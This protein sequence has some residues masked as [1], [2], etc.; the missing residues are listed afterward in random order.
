VSD[1]TE[2]ESVMKMHLVL[3]AA[4][5]GLSSHAAFAGDTW[6]ELQPNPHVR[7]VQPLT[8]PAPAPVS[9]QQRD[10]LGATPARYDG[11]DTWS[12]LA[13]K[14]SHASLTE[15]LT[16]ATT[17]PLS[18]LHHE[19]PSVYGTSVQADT[20]DRIVRLAPDS[21]S[22][23]VAYGESVEFIVRGE[24]GAER[25]FAWRFDGSP[26]RSYVDLSEVAPAGFPD[27]SLR[28]FVAPDARYRGE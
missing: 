1:F 10:D 12:D 14:S 21:H 5:T 6:S 13:P 15:S 16:V 4:L 18:T 20:A 24:S 3:A 11:G 9:S 17:A 23:N 19:S 2:K 25:S 22:I 28:V 8:A 7:S 27:Q 26:S